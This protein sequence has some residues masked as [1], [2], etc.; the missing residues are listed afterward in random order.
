MVFS[1]RESLASKRMRLTLIVMLLVAWVALY[2]FYFWREAER[3]LAMDIFMII[4]SICMIAL[5]G[6]NIAALVKNI[7]SDDTEDF[8]LESANY[9]FH[10]MNL[11]RYVENG[12]FKRMGEWAKDNFSYEAAAIAMIILKDNKSA[13]LHHGTYKDKRCKNS[14]IMDKHAWVEFRIGLRLYVADLT[15]DKIIYSRREYFGEDGP[16]KELVSRWRCNHDDFWVLAL[17]T[18]VH[19]AMLVPTT[20]HVMKELS[21]FGDPTALSFG[22]ANWAARADGMNYSD[23]TYMEPYTRSYVVLTSDIIRDFGKKHNRQQPKSKSMRRAKR[24]IRKSWLS[25]HGKT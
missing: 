6:T 9:F 22:F 18:A 12:S 17:V 1:L 25:K 13:I 19:D 15:T 5:C 7:I 21:G 23:G 2:L 4:G 3:T 20:S 16:G 24:E 11:I 10:G 14:H 8:M